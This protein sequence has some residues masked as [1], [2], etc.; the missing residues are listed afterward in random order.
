M[1]AK[2][3]KTEQKSKQRDDMVFELKLNHK[4]FGRMIFLMITKGSDAY[5]LQ[6][7]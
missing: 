6:Y 7:I 4:G 5:G 2:V 1:K 3:E